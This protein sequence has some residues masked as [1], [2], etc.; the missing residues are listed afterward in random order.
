MQ[1]FALVATM[2]IFVAAVGFL[3]VQ[4]KGS[5]TPLPSQHSQGI[6]GFECADRTGGTPGVATPPKEVLVSTHGGFDRVMFSFGSAASAIPTYAVRED[7]NFSLRQTIKG[8][9]FLVVSFSP[10]LP[11]PSTVT[12]GVIRSDLINIGTLLPMDAQVVR[13]VQL[14]DAGS[15]SFNFAIGLSSPTCFRVTEASNPPRLLIDF[16]SSQTFA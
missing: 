13:D 16:D 15:R 1:Q 10:A 14:V 3:I 6:S 11:T 7:A 5:R 2:V 9:S 4:L 12:S 8:S